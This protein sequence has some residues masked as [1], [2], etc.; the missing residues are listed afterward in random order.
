MCHLVFAKKDALSVISCK[1]EDLI[2]TL[3]KYYA[4]GYLLTHFE[5]S[6]PI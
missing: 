2:K 1:P 5:Y 4:D 6:G 3:R